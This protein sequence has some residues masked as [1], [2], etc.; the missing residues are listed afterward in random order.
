M[1]RPDRFDLVFGAAAC[2][3]AVLI[4]G[5]GAGLTFFSDEWAFIETR[6]LGD[7]ATWFAPHNEHWATLSILAYRLLVETV[8]IGSYMPYLAVLVG[9]HVL[10]A[11][12]VY[13]LARRVAS[14]WVAVAAGVVVLF[15]GAGFENLFWAFQIG[16]V[17]ATAA[18]LAAIL[19]FDAS[20][21][22]AGRAFIGAGLLVVSLALQGGPG[23]VFAV[24]VA[25]ELLIDPRRRW[26]TIALAI[27]AAA[28][29]VWY[30]AIG[31]V[32]VEAHEGLF[33]L[34]GVADIPP[35]VLIGFS[36]VAGAIA[37]VGS[38]L[39]TWVLAAL[40]LAAAAN[41]ISRRRVPAIAPRFVAS[42][43]A[44]T[45]FYVLISLA[46]SSIGPDT[47]ALTRYTYIGTTLFLVGLTAQIGHPSL[48]DAGT[49]R[50]WMVGVATVMALALTWNLRMMVAGRGLFAD[51][52]ER[53]RALVTVA[54]ERPLPA[55]TDPDRS[56]VLVPS[57][58]ALA[59]IV[60]AYGSPI[61][62]DL[63]PWAVPSIRP[64]VLADAER[65]LREG[66]VIPLP[67]PTTR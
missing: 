65:V 39:G 44:I 54:L 3:A 29:A 45:V 58:N 42:V 22:T 4:L 2:T 52:A 48:A 5:L 37:G 53:T 55:S 41:V 67:E 15:L 60:G 46:R 30:L 63:V 34:G 12:L 32:G 18:G 13:R 7:P 35:M 23:L 61:R 36:S 62:D 50:A 11:A 64:E 43:A 8:G 24:S 27:P 57:P 56:L 47:A 66:A 31:R 21:P 59:R 38:E 10:V 25:V 28:Y 49:R 6:S 26:M 1:R 16:F 40:V 9:L 14:P 17:G 51:R 33:R 19:A 20:P